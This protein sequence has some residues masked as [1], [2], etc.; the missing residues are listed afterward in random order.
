MN[1]HR[2]YYHGTA[3]LLV[4]LL[5]AGWGAAARGKHDP[6]AAANEAVRV[7]SASVPGR[8]VSKFI[9]QPLQTNDGTTLGTLHD[10]LVDVYS[11]EVLYAAVGDP[12]GAEPPRLVP[13]AAINRQGDRMTVAFDAP[14]WQQITPVNPHQFADGRVTLTPGE[15]RMLARR[16]GQP[17]SEEPLTPTGLVAVIPPP[18]TPLGGSHLARLGEL[19]G[20][21]I[22][23]GTEIIGGI[24]DIVIGPDRGSAAALVGPDKNLSQRR[25]ERF[26]VPLQHLN[27]AARDQNPIATTLKRSDFEEAQRAPESR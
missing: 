23:T 27:L 15:R 26:L 19:R 1:A 10:V 24:D 13:L 3:A 20:R 5:V 8:S 7:V 18:A 4:G 25:G 6:A 14:Q 11:G 12:D 17:E 9:G 22:S 16:F 21:R 2:L